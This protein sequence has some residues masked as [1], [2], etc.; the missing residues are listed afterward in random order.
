MAI[1]DRRPHDR[2]VRAL[3]C[4]DDARHRRDRNHRHV[5]ER[6]ENPFGVRSDDQIHT[7]PE[8]RELSSRRIDVAYDQRR[9]SRATQYIY[10]GVVIATSHDDELGD[11]GF[12]KRLD[13]SRHERTTIRARQ[14]RFRRPHAF[15]ITGSENDSREH[16]SV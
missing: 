13:D 9:H 6:D 14:K 2:C 12:V 4:G 15:R 1:A 5:N 3:P 8:R 7:D 10:E 11:A 16:T